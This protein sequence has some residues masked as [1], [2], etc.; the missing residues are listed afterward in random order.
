L[1][2]RVPWLRAGMLCSSL[3]HTAYTIRVKLTVLWHHVLCVRCRN[4]SVMY[5]GFGTV[6][7]RGDNWIRCSHDSLVTRRS[8]FF[9]FTKG[10]LMA[11]CAV[12]L[13]AQN[14]RLLS[15]GLEP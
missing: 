2:E 10:R 9:S 7:N 5:Y 15:D 6:L 8:W 1:L 13:T 12:G 11:G 3:S 14:E 4:Y